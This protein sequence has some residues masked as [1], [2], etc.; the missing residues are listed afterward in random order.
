MTEGTSPV[1]ALW[2]DFG[3]VLTPPVRA[4]QIAFC[5]RLGIAPDVLRRAVGRVTARYGCE[6]PMEP[7][8]TPLVG[9]DDWTRQVEEV[10]AREFSV[11]VR[12]ENFAEAWFK[13]R[14]VNEEWLSWLRLVRSR[15]IFV[16][17]L[18]NMVPTWDEHWRRMVPPEGTFDRVLLSFEAGCRKPSPDIFALAEKAAGIPAAHSVLVDD[19][20][21]NCAGAEEAGWRAIEFTD[22]TEA[23]SRLSAWLGIPEGPAS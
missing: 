20:A 15:G 4:S 22:T 23:I 17:L 8:D 5:A 12:I 14:P 19:M 1:R 9:E 3:G 6:D 16:G 10:L 13:D 11:R 7:L 21:G 18:S 2:T